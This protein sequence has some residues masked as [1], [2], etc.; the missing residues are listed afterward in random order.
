MLNL[1]A[2]TEHISPPGHGGECR[3]RTETQATHA[4]SQSEAGSRCRAS[5]WCPS[6]HP[7]C[8]RDGRGRNCV[9][10]T[11]RR[12]IDRGR[13]REECETGVQVSHSRIPSGTTWYPR[14]TRVWVCLFDRDECPWRVSPAVAASDPVVS[15]IR[16][17]NRPGPSLLWDCS[18]SS[19]ANAREDPLLASHP[20]PMETTS[21][22]LRS[23]RRS[24]YSGLV[25]ARA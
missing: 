19:W 10:R 11:A 17:I 12:R 4:K 23:V 14:D 6:T 8:Q 3:K 9:P 24:S 18:P 20:T 13:E 16:S 22:Y 25:V 7:R 2:L 5:G 15:E 21:S 1:S